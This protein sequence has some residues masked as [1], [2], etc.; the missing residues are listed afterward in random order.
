[1]QYFS[2]LAVFIA[3]LGLLGLSS[4]TTQN[5]RKEIGIRKIN[6]A[7]TLE[8]VALLTKDFSLLILII[9]TPVAYYFSNLWLDNF[10]YKTE[11]GVSI[12][13]FAG[14]ISLLLAVLTVSYHTVKAAMTN[15][16]NSLR[17]E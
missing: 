5:R 7:S 1:M 3:C 9:A 4:F 15:P 6:G 8:L 2:I 14:L 13:I 12:F 11:I 10:A 17:Y 16:I